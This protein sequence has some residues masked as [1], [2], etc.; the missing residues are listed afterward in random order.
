MD[1][2]DAIR[3]SYLTKGFTEANLQ[4]LYSIARSL[5]FEDGEEILRQF[6]NSRDLLIVASG[7]VTI[8]TDR[9]EP[10]GQISPGMPMGE[11]S[12]LD[13]KPRSGTAVANGEVSIVV[14]PADQLML[15]LRDAPEM[16]TKCLWNI[17]SVLCARLRTANHS[18]ASLMVVGETSDLPVDFD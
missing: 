13:G 7:S 11:V 10:I 9:G 3:L 5:T 6:D 18:I 4:G 16:A 8:R 17:A 12:F 2:K 1:L 15:I 14:L